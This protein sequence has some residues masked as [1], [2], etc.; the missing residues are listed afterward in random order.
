MRFYR[1]L[2]RHTVTAGNSSRI[3]EGMKW[4]SLFHSALWLAHMFWVFPKLALSRECPEQP[5]MFVHQAT[6]EELGTLQISVL[7][8]LSRLGPLP[9]LCS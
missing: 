4:A 6:A 2:E 7:Q 1:H 8:E 3:K 9:P 5:A